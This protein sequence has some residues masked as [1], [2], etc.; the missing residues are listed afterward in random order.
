MGF[1]FRVLGFFLKCNG[2]FTPPQLRSVPTCSKHT[3]KT[4][5]N[6]GFRKSDDAPDDAAVRPCR[7]FK[8]LAGSSS[9]QQVLFHV[10]RHDKI[11]CMLRRE[12]SG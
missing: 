10:Q 6:Q 8:D 5:P 1:G 3:L 7:G 4:P 12:A 2:S 11:C 9:G